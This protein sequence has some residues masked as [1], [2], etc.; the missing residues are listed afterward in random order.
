M[1]IIKPFHH[2]VN[3]ILT[4]VSAKFHDHRAQYERVIN[5]IVHDVPATYPAAAF[6]QVGMDIPDVPSLQ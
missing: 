4:H 2:R 5:V 1:T 6:L 3:I